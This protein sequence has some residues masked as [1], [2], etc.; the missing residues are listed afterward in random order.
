LKQRGQ[1]K[2]QRQPQG[3]V[4]D[5][6]R[7]DV[8]A[9]AQWKRLPAGSVPPMEVHLPVQPTRRNLKSSRRFGLRV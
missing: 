1:E 7:P 6:A 4:P 2:W 5:T 9:Q 3:N 8:A